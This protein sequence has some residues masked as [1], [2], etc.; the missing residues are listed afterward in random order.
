MDAKAC[1]WLDDKDPIHWC[2][3][4][5]SVYQKCDMLCN[6]LCEVCTSLH[7]LILTFSFHYIFIV[8]MYVQGLFHCIFIV[9]KQVFNSKIGGPRNKPIHGLMGGL[10][11]Y[12]MKRMQL[13][14]DRPLKWNTRLICPSIVEKLDA[15]KED[16]RGCIPTYAG[17]SK[18][19]VIE[20]CVDQF[21]VN[22]ETMECTCRK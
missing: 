10:R 17:Y 2:R 1:A 5:F 3:A 4:H 9:K 18:Y 6:N 12:C 13:A 11:E 8:T 16:S 7:L 21:A 14:R 19:Q 20:M 15:L 22:L